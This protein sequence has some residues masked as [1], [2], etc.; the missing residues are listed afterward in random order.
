MLAVT[1][2][3]DIF[4]FQHT[5]HFYHTFRMLAVPLQ[6]L[7]TFSRFQKIPEKVLREG[8]HSPPSHHTPISFRYILNGWILPHFKG[9]D[10]PREVSNETLFRL[11]FQFLGRASLL[12]VLESFDALKCISSEPPEQTVHTLHQVCR[13]PA[14]K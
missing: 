3:S 11:F 7:Y 14:P 4:T 6:G 1:P 10:H 9:I 5:G 2:H 13:V 8:S 12:F